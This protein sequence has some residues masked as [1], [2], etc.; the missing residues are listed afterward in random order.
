MKDPIK[1]KELVLEKVEL[2]D[3]MKHYNVKFAYSPDHAE[4]VQFSCP[5]H[6]KDNK[7]SARFYRATQS[8]YCW[9][10][11][12]KW[13]AVSFIRDKENLGFNA[14]IKHLIDWFKIDTSSIPDDPEFITPKTEPVLEEAIVSRLIRNRLKEL[15]GKLSFEKFNAVCSAYFLILYE[16]SKGIKVLDKMNLLES[17]LSSLKV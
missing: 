10:C 15:R 7:P 16:M 5:F 3:V 1:L 17:K 6:G 12:R 2:L 8:C 13:D 4:E 9:V 14:S 11:R